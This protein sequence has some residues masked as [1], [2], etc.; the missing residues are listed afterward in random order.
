MSIEHEI[1]V[2]KPNEEHKPLVTTPELPDHIASRDN[3]GLSLDPLHWAK[4]NCKNCLGRGVIMVVKFIDASEIVKGAD[5]KGSG[6]TMRSMETCG[7]S[8]RGYWRVRAPLEDSILNIWNNK[9]LDEGKK[10][11]AAQAV[12]EKAHE[13]VK[14]KG[15]TSRIDL[16]KI[17]NEII[18]RK[19]IVPK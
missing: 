18:Q 12:I 6:N 9:N 17:A 4:H 15:Y 13:Q 11:E 8:A 14:Q 7:C 5:V 19:L 2:G 10:V 1:K 16:A 3:L